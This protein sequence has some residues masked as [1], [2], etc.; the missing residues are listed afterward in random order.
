MK[1]IVT[2][3]TAVLLAIGSASAWGAF[4]HDVVV[5]IAKA[6]LTERAKKNIAKYM[7]YDITSESS[8]M[9]YHRDD[10]D[11]AYTHAWHVF[12]SDKHRK[13]DPNPRL[14]KGGDAVHAM[15]IADYNLS[16]Y[17]ELSDSTVV[18]NLRLALHFTGDT[19]CPTHFY[20]PGLRCHWPCELNG[21]AYEWF[22][23]VY[24]YMPDML[25]KGKSAT[26]LA[27]E[28]DNASKS[29]RKRICR[30]TIHDWIADCIVHNRAIYE[31][32]AHGTKVL[33]PNTPELSRELVNIQLRNAGYRLACLLNRYFDK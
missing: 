11:L 1:R 4:G 8:W 27:V 19:H 20:L 3:C 31:W 15:K 30:G 28:L 6:H 22:H 32:N 14:Y 21:K 29:E 13:Y 33:D 12:C 24:D 23:S 26:E 9:D 16:R 7:P 25:H 10:K 18:M 5:E 17:E 2:L